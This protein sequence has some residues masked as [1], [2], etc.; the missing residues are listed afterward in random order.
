LTPSYSRHMV[1]IKHVGSGDLIRH[2]AQAGFVMRFW[3]IA[4]VLCNL[5]LSLRAINPKRLGTNSS[6]RSPQ[7]EIPVPLTV[8]QLEPVEGVIPVYL[9][10]APTVL[11]NRSAL[12]HIPCK[13]KNNNRKP[14]RGL[15]LGESITIESGGHV[16]S[17]DGYVAID[18]FVHRDLHNSA[19][20]TGIEPNADAQ[21]PSA[22]ET[23]NGTITGLKVYVDF[24]EFSDR[25]T[26]GPNK[27]GARTLAD[28]REGASRYKDWF[29]GQYESNGRSPATLA[30]LIK[31]NRPLDN[32]FKFTSGGQEQGA[33]IYRKW[34]RNVYEKEGIPGVIKHLSY[35]SS[36]APQSLRFKPR[37]SSDQPPR[38]TK[39]LQL[40]KEYV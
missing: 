11:T 4:V 14:I 22:A 31:D 32:N 33:L 5:P 40:S 21:F 3:V 7:Q 23:F 29:I 2:P 38:R 18:N 35:P 34:L 27:A 1:T 24:V 37:E 36:P 26:V 10:C 25:Q 17:E 30:T 12:E 13:I 8:T 9:D 19:N 28:I 15:V 20:G 16:L 6:L 39:V